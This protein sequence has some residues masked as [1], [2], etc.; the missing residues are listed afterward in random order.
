MMAA[1]HLPNG[2]VLTYDFHRK[3]AGRFFYATPIRQHDLSGDSSIT[4][5]LPFCTEYQMEERTRRQP[6][7]AA[8]AAFLGSAV[9]YYDLFCYGTAAALVFGEIFFATNNPFVGTLASLVTF[10]VGFIARPFGALVFGYLGDKIGRRYSLIIT[11]LVMGLASTLIGALPTYAQIGPWAAVLLLILRVA[12]GIAV[13]GEWGGAVLIAAEHASP[14]WRTFL[15]AAPQYGNPIGLILASLA[16]QWATS[17]PHDDFRTW[18][19][20]IPFLASAVLVLLTFIIRHGVSESPEIVDFRNRASVA[21]RETKRSPILEI[22]KSHKRRVVFGV[23]F[24]M[25]AVAGFYFVTTLMLTVTTTYLGIARPA[26]LQV[27]NYTGIVQLIG[28]PIGSYLAHRFG[29]RRYLLAITTII[30][31]WSA[32][33]MML[34]FTRD[35]RYI[36][37]SILITNLLTSGYYAV[38]ASFLPKAFPVQVRYTGISISYQLCSAVFGGTTPLVGLWVIRSFGVH[39]APLAIMFGL[40]A[41]CTLISAALLPAEKLEVDR[42]APGE[43]V[44]SA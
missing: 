37:A 11:L 18:G 2:E 24:T 33:M 32:P 36:E 27:M 9:E 16:F 12:Q 34:I 4:T 30:F 5:K 10:A 20:R 15:A 40:M 19:W 3:H 23:G 14:R 21:A 41:L 44:G 42:I 22:L 6:C 29:E 25:M 17:L 35:I 1:N 43:A 7:R 39:W 13:G 31:L 38:L 28:Y 26:I 8:L